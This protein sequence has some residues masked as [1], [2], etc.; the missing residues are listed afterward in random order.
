MVESIRGLIPSGFSPF[1]VGSILG[2]VHLGLSL[3]RFSLQIPYL[4][5]LAR[6]PI[7]EELDDPTDLLEHRLDQ[8]LPLLNRMSSYLRYCIEDSS[9]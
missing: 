6:G 5:Y 4:P 7:F 3:S 9:L 8:I 1:G 2:L